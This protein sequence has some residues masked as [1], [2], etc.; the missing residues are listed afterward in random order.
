MNW[1]HQQLASCS[2][3]LQ[4]FDHDFLLWNIH[5]S[6]NLFPI[7]SFKCIETSLIQVVT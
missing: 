4:M 5:F 1:C 6:G 7:V 2:L 3:D